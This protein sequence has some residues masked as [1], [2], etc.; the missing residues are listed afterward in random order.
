AAFPPEATTT[1]LSDKAPASRAETTA[2]ALPRAPVNAVAAQSRRNRRFEAA[3]HTVNP[4]DPAELRAK[5]AAQ[6]TDVG[7][8]GILDLRRARTVWGATGGR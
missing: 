8:P 4:M 1:P 7:A 3:G 2:F 5:I 6:S